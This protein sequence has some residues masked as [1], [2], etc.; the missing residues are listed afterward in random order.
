M[1]ITALLDLSY[2]DCG[3]AK[4]ID[5]LSKDY[6]IICRYCGSSNSGHTIVHDNKKYLTRILPSGVLRFDKKLLIGQGVLLDVDVFLRELEQFKDYNILERLIVSNKCHLLLPYHKQADIENEINTDNKIGSTRNGVAFCAQD[7]IGRRGIRVVDVLNDF[8]NIYEKVMKNIDFWQISDSHVICNETMRLLINFVDILKKN[9]IFCDTDLFINNQCDSYKFLAE[10]SQGHFL[11]I[12]NGFYPYCTSVPCTAAGVCLGLNI[13]PN[14]LSKVIGL[15]KAYTT[16]VGN[17]PF[18]T[19]LFDSIADIIRING[20]EFGSVTK[21]PRR[22]GWLNLDELKTAC[23]I[24][25]VDELAITKTDVLNG[26][27]GV[28]VLVNNEY[29]KMNGWNS[30][31][32][33]SFEDYINFIESFCKTRISYV[34]YGPDREEVQVR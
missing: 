27:N 3:K 9:N 21:R 33:K 25:G 28:C 6:D 11:D 15:T 16:R 24:N 10:S 20:N 30:Y 23:L 29:V 7:K 14:R 13:P 26:M 1:S 4:F 32:D 18:K 2:G 8:D 5:Y 17:G 34:S 19:E 31:K 22:V 12:E